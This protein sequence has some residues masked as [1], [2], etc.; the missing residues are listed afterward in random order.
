MASGLR[1]GVSLMTSD[2]QLNWIVDS[3]PVHYRQTEGGRVH[4]T[5]CHH[6]KRHVRGHRGRINSGS[7]VVSLWSR[8]R[9]QSRDSSQSGARA[10]TRQRHNSDT[11]IDHH[12][13]LYVSRLVMGRFT[14][15]RYCFDRMISENSSSAP[16]DVQWMMLECSSIRVDLRSNVN[17]YSL[18]ARWFFCVPSTKVEK[19]HQYKIQA[20]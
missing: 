7:P 3:E 5:G 17:Q 2:K 14:Q 9:H 15:F 4:Y 6:L 11:S 10:R 20:Q 13:Q 1:L 16:G 12:H 18:T 19:Q 8:W